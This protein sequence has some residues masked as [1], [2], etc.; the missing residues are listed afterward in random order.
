LEHRACSRAKQ[1]G[2]ASIV[3]QRMG[4]APLIVRANTKTRGGGDHRVDREHIA[5]HRR[6]DGSYPCG[7]GRASAG[8]IEVERAAHRLL[9]YTD[10]GLVFVDPRQRIRGCFM[11]QGGMQIELLQPEGEGSPLRPH[12]TRGI[13]MYRKRFSAPTL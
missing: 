10:E 1:K 11:V 9:G 3:A 4:A 7:D 12:L 8:D 2:A 5:I 6:T 13:K